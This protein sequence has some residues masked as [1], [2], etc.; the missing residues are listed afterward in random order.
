M[1]DPRQ[2]LGGLVLG[3]QFRAIR[4]VTSSPHRP[5]FDQGAARGWY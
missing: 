3:R 4:K 1:V 2:L 5:G